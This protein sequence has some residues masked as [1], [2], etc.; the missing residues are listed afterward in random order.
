MTIFTNAVKTAFLLGLMMALCLGVG[1][2][3]GR[4][5][6]MMIGFAFG[7]IGALVSYFFSDKIALASVG[8]AAGGAEQRGAL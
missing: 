4:G 1:Y 6:G 7:G 8:G 5:Q 3:C 2:A